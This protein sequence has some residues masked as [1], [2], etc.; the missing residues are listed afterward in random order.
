MPSL[1]A[2]TDGTNTTILRAANVFKVL[3]TVAIG[4]IATVWTPASGKKIRLMGG[5]ISVSAAANVLFED[6]SHSSTTNYVVRTPTLA[7]DTA[8]NFD[9][10]NGILLGT[11]DHV[12]K[13]TSSASANVVGYLYGTEE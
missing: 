10:G 5:S 3:D 6:N 9:L 4:S 2:Y 8:Y 11:A 13:A 12:L 1:R 7:T